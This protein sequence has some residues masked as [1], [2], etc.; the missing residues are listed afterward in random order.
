MKFVI[1]KSTGLDEQVFIELDDL[2]EG[3]IAS[4]FKAC[5][6]RLAQ[7]NRKIV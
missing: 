2:N 4:A 1:Q 7:T 5:D 3:R 6:E